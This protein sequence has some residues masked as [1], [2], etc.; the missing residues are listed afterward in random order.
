[1]TGGGGARTETGG[2]RGE[3]GCG[4]S[5]S[6]GFPWFDTRRSC[7]GARGI[8]D[9]RGSPATVSLRNP[10]DAMARGEIAGLRKLLDGERERT[11]GCRGPGRGGVA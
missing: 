3:G 9:V 1:M 2:A 11:R 10:G 8:R 5:P 7:E 6:I 4:R